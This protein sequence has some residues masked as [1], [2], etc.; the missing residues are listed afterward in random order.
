MKQAHFYSYLRLPNAKAPGCFIVLC[1]VSG[2]PRPALTNQRLTECPWY[3][4][5]RGKIFL[6]YFASH[7]G[8]CQK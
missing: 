5:G 1:M 3:L 6:Y 8:T 7:T 4:K 2:H